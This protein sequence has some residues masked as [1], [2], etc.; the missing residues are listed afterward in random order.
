MAFSARSSS[1]VLPAGK[2]ARGRTPPALKGSRNARA[3]RSAPRAA[4]VSPGRVKEETGRP[5]GTTRRRQ[6]KPL[7]YEEIASLYHGNEEG[8]R[9]GPR[10]HVTAASNYKA[11]YSSVY[12]GFVTDYA[13]MNVPMDDHMVHRG[14]AVFDTTNIIDGYAW[15][16]E[17]HLDR[18]LRSA[19]IA[20]IDVERLELGDAYDE[21]EAE[22][23]N[24]AGFSDEVAMVRA[25][26]RAIALDMISMAGL[27]NGEVRFWL[28]SGVGNFNLDPYD[29][30]A[31]TLYMIAMERNQAFRTELPA[32][33]RVSTT[34]VP[35]KP[36]PYCV[37]KSNNYLQNAHAL[38]DARD[39]GSDYGVFVY[40]N[41]EGETC[42]SEGPNCNVV[43]IDAAG[44]VVIPTFE[45]ALRGV[46][47][48]RTVDLI[49]RKLAKVSLLLRPH[50]HHDL[51]LYR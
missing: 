43:F 47:I 18:F 15:G 17:E 31:P 38:M 20:R 16:F 50:K 9:A 2:G 46:T 5:R 21:M 6:L 12:G 42:I 45:Y 3:V 22:G 11:F 26:I 41:A 7:S 23:P 10:Y 25:K 28:S 48:L 30:V 40:E 29:C 36:N 4:P 8:G 39:Q 27:R 24:S 49:E 51:H 19:A 34:S 14:H 13:L 37:V 44:R 32:A 1:S 35:M 33:L